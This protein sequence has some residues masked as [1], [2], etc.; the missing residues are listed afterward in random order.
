MRRRGPTGLVAGSRRRWRG[1][2]NAGGSGLNDLTMLVNMYALAVVETPC[3]VAKPTPRCLKLG[4]FCAILVRRCLRGET[5]RVLWG[6]EH[7]A[8]VRSVA[9]LVRRVAAISRR[10]ATITGTVR[11]MAWRVASSR[12]RGVAISHGMGRLVRLGYRPWLAGPAAGRRDGEKRLAG[13]G[14]RIWSV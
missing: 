3:T 8:V 10:L 4:D 13:G 12:V 2:R 11:A 9:F 1:L 14:V 6:Y 5:G 7:A